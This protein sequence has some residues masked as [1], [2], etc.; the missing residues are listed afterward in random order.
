ML[1]RVYI[2]VY[3]NNYCNWMIHDGEAVLILTLWS[4][5]DIFVTLYKALI[6]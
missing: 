6:I 1:N 2:W 4:Y 5:E 3:I